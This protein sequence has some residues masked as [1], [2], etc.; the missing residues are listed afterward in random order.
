MRVL[1]LDPPASIT[2]LTGVNYP[3]PAAPGRLV[4]S[5]ELAFVAWHADG[6]RV[7]DVGQVRPRTVAQFVPATPAPAVVG[8]AVLGPYLMVT[9]AGSGLYVL[10]RPDEGTRESLWS[11]IKGA[12]GFMSIPLLLGAVWAVPRLAMGAQP[13][14]GRSPV[15][16]PAGRRRR[17]V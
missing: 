2:E 3:S 6:L 17:R 4:A 8:V 16:V 15:P 13:V 1:A 10:R 5:G 14:T 11:K 12:A 7:L 9:D